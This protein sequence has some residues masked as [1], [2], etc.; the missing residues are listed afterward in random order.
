MKEILNVDETAKYLGIHPHTVYK[1]ANE[2]K[3][4]HSRLGR[5]FKFCKS[6]LDKKISGHD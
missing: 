5:Q 6:A 1:L 2:G 3:L 4:P